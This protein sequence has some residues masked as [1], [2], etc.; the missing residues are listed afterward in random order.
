MYQFSIEKYIQFLCNC[1]KKVKTQEERNQILITTITKSVYRYISNGLFN[2]D[3]TVYSFLLAVNVLIQNS[4]IGPE[5]WLIFI[6]GGGIALS[7]TQYIDS[8]PPDFISSTSWKI[9]NLIEAT[10]PA[11]AALQLTRKIKEYSEQWQNWLVSANADFGLLVGFE[12]LS[13]FHKLLLVKILRPEKSLYFIIGTIKGALGEYF[14]TEQTIPTEK[15]AKYISNRF[16]MLFLL[17]PGD[18]PASMLF[19]LAKLHRNH[20]IDIIALGKNQDN[21]VKSSIKKG[22]LDGR[23]I[24]VENC[25]LSSSFLN[26]LEN[27]VEN[28]LKTPKIHSSFRLFFSSYPTPLF[29]TSVLQNMFI[30]TIQQRTGLKHIINQSLRL[31]TSEIVEKEN[32]P[33]C[34]K[35]CYALALF[36]GIVNERKKFG[37][38]GWNSPYEFSQS[39]FESGL[40]LLQMLEN[41]YTDM[42]LTRNII[43]TIIYGGLITDENDRSI[44]YEL[45]HIYLNNEML[46][47]TDYFITDSYKIPYVTSIKD[48]KDYAMDLSTEEPIEL[49]G[50]HSNAYINSE[51]Q[52]NSRLLSSLRLTQD[53]SLSNFKGKSIELEINKF[54]ILVT[55]LPD[56]IKNCTLKQALNSETLTPIDIYCIQEAERMNTLLSFIKN[57]L[58]TIHQSALG[59]TIL[60]TSLEPTIYSIGNN[61]IP[62]S[63]KSLDLGCYTPLSSWLESL[64][65]RFEFISKCLESYQQG[66]WL[67][68]FIYPKGFFSSI[69]QAHSRA[70]NVSVE[71]LAFSFEISEQ[72]PKDGIYI[73]GIYLEGCRWDSVSNTLTN[74]YP[75]KTVYPAPYII[76][77]PTESTLDFDEYAIP[78]YKSQVRSSTYIISIEFPTNYKPAYWTLQNPALVSTLND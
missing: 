24:L 58:E 28:L 16:F 71:N 56:V 15:L 64:R 60:P 34:L 78:L 39:D 20:L 50:L 57:E 27:E 72:L 2:Q 42:F 70:Y 76:I 47:K 21:R 19:K 7:L 55:N 52:E 49:F 62:S 66:F 14:I 26:E 6:R 67:A 30:L 75:L 73:Y 25:H 8:S 22:I 9:L 44:L 29:P 37:I 10:I 53:Q 1:I 54:N 41:S 48:L 69:L 11:F 33:I 18:D 74:A 23:W 43:S 3:K 46:A 61:Q 35:L 32:T 17:S 12:T 77:L 5:E 31:V 38:I 45:S 59:Q 51:M 13:H 36:H 63:W 68:A 4:E 40:A 65:A